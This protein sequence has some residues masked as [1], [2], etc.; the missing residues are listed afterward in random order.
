MKLA[1]YK[2]THSGYKGLGNILIRWRLKGIHS[3]SELVF[4]PED[5]VSHLMPD[6]SCEPID[7][8]YWCASS[9]GTDVLPMWSSRR[10]G[11]YG[12]VRF[13]R[14]KLDLENWDLVEV[15]QSPIKAAQWFKTNEG[16]LY[17]WQLILGGLAWF[18]PNKLSRW[19]CSESCA[20]ALGYS[21]PERFDPCTLHAA[22][23]NNI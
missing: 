20:T 23:S 16:A 6:G 11:K 17:D 8:A 22:V 3:H 5:N 9:T 14:V 18:I 4:T 15:K 13:K 10:A 21:S 7:G 1:S 12:G 19:M 2:G